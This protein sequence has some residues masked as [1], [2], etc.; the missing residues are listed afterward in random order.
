MK[1]KRKRT[2]KKRGMRKN[3]ESYYEDTYR[4]K[5][6]GEFRAYCRN[7]E[8]VRLVHIGN[9]RGEGGRRKS[10]LEFKEKSI[11][12]WLEASWPGKELRF[13]RLNIP[14]KNIV[15]VEKEKKDLYGFLNWGKSNKFLYLSYRDNGNI[16]TLRFGAGADFVVANSQH[17]D[18]AYSR[19]KAHMSLLKQE[20]KEEDIKDPLTILKIRY[21]K[22]EITKKEYEQMKKDIEES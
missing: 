7:T 9:F 5:Q 2:N 13:I 14:W 10:Y 22:G 11:L 4:F 18:I 8:G 3:D 21:A 16:S 19:I 17:V 1:R 15:D 20:K 12:V 6:K